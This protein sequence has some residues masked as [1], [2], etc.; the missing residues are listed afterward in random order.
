MLLWF[1]YLGTS[2]KTAYFCKVAL[3]L[4]IRNSRKYSKNTA[5]IPKILL[6]TYMAPLCNIFTY[7]MFGHC[8]FFFFFLHGTLFRGSF[9]QRKRVIIIQVNANVCVWADKNKETIC[10]HRRHLL[11]KL[12]TS[13]SSFDCMLYCLSIKNGLQ[14]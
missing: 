10:S 12:M 2:D 5:W 6:F 7:L 3:I 11:S 8:M 13:F 14:D 4:F 9:L 1:K